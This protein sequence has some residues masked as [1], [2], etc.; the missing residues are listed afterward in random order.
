MLSDIGRD[1]PHPDLIREFLREA[2]MLKS[3]R[4]VTASDLRVLQRRTLAD[5]PRPFDLEGNESVSVVF[6]MSPAAGTDDIDHL[7]VYVARRVDGDDRWKTAGSVYKPFRAD[8]TTPWT[9]AITIDARQALTVAAIVYQPEIDALQIE[10]PDGTVFEDQAGEGSV[11][12]YAPLR[13][14]DRW[15]GEAII[16]MI[17]RSGKTIEATPIP[18]NPRPAS[19]TDT[20]PDRIRG[21]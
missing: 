2:A 1:G 3:E 18:L 8:A 20:W 15:S 9:G 13:S 14:P 5:L 11:L 16:R 19:F 12:I 17:D 6:A 7:I 10:L 4:R 21:K